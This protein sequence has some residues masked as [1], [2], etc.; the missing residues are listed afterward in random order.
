MS[1]EWIVHLFE[2]GC[3]PL[4]EEG[5][6]SDGCCYLWS[7]EDNVGYAIDGAIGCAIEVGIPLRGEDGNR[8]SARH[9]AEA[10]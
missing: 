4:D 10:S 5:C 6:N 8:E 7:V 1:S 9:T 2:F 3:D